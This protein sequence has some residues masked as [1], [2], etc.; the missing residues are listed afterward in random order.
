MVIDMNLKTKTEAFLVKLKKLAWALDV[1]QKDNCTIADA[2]K[3]W[4]E[5][6]HFFF[7]P[8]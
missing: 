4:I 7:K 3:M 5:L 2:V 6:K 1:S 8:V